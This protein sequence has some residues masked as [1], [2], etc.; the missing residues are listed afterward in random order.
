[1]KYLNLIVC[2]LIVYSC[3]NKKSLI[4][5]TY[6]S[7]I[8]EYRAE[9]LASRKAGYLQLAGL[10]KLDSINSFGKGSEN[11]IEL[12]I[13][14][15]P[16]LIGT[17]ETINDTLHFRA[18]DNVK[19]TT[20]T[21]SVLTLL[22][23]KLD[24]YGSSIKMFYKHINWQVI[25]R[26]GTRYLR[27]WN[28][29]NPAIEAF[30]GFEFFDLNPAMILQGDFTYYQNEKNQMVASQL[31]V[32]TNTNFIGKVTF[33]YNGEMHDL[34]VGNNG[35][36]MVADLTSGE[37]TYGGG[38]YIYLELPKESGTV[39]IDFNKL[40]N[41]PCSFSAYTTCLY[42]PRQNHLPFDIMA[43][44]TITTINQP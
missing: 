17:I 44:E 20:K 12:T 3:D 8:N 39:E 36:T 30:T 18:A 38:R 32:D 15:I 22:P 33:E 27:I 24:T 41:P 7:T 6:K 34:D 1:M 5:A 2:L 42:P 16:E 14:D 10:Y 29:K 9:R 43:G 4:S 37:T 31:G 13:D 11:T 21:D 26:S 23:L 35:F 19:I 40:Y 28:K 25:T